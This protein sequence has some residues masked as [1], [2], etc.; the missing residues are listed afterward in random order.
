[1]NMVS[2]TIMTYLNNT[3]INSDA[4]GQYA[5]FCLMNE[6]YV[7]NEWGIYYDL[8]NQ[9][10]YTEE[11]QNPRLHEYFKQRNTKN[12]TENDKKARQRSYTNC[13]NTVPT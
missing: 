7:H 12:R 6:I 1:M 11:F 13:V 3:I 10:H 9:N 2:A 4:S 8:L 5:T